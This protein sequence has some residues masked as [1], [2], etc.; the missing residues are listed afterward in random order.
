MKR[1]RLQSEGAKRD[2]ESKGTQFTV[3]FETE[4]YIVVKG[5][6]LGEREM[7]LQK[8]ADGSFVNESNVRYD[9]VKTDTRKKPY[10]VKYE[11]GIGEGSSTTKFA[12]LEEVQEYVKGRWCGADYI[13]G[14]ETFHN[15]YGHFILKGCTLADL[16]ARDA[17]DFYTW[18]WKNLSQPSMSDGI[19]PALIEEINAETEQSEADAEFAAQRQEEAQSLAADML[20]A[21]YGF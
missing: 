1:I 13:D 11:S 2:G 4:N 5:A 6:W 19:A 12:T 10:S 14:V 15:D 7:V 3:D 16:G 21:Q 17:Q 20:D 9:R 18:N 8:Q